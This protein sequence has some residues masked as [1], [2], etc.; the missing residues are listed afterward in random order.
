[1]VILL[2]PA[3]CARRIA[4]CASNAVTPLYQENLQKNLTILAQLNVPHFS[5]YALTI[6]SGTLLHHQV[7]KQQ[8]HTLPDTAYEYCFEQIHQFAQEN[9]YEHYEISNFAQ[10]NYRSI[11]NANYWN[12]K[13]YIGVGPSAHSFDG[14]SIR[15]WNIAN[16][17][18]YAQKVTN[19]DLYFE[20][21]IL[22][23]ENKWN[24]YLMTQLR[25][26]KG[27]DLQFVKD[28]FPEKYTTGLF[29]KLAHLPGEWYRQN[30]TT[31]SLT[32]KGWLVSDFILK[33]LMI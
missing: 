33:K 5:A 17:H 3:S 11:H 25:T 4:E 22:S 10:K 26:A 15:R 7:K 1:M 16:N 27:I 20:Q 2:K 12:G 32:V 31:F 24:E 29:R 30:N 28:N 18:L 21:E 19:G 8:Y 23:E 13:P 9:G 6:E 14:S